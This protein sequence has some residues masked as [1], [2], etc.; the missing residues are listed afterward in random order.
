MN[1]NQVMKIIL[2]TV[3]LSSCRWWLKP[4]ALSSSPYAVASASGHGV[5]PRRK[6]CSAVACSDHGDIC[7]RRFLE[8]SKWPFSQSTHSNG[9]KLFQIS[10]IHLFELLFFFIFSGNSEFS[11]GETFTN[12]S[13]RY[14]QVYMYCLNNILGRSIWENILETEAIRQRS[15]IVQWTIC[16]LYQSQVLKKRFLNKAS[17]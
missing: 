8:Y 11:N 4:T 5:W 17:G 13:Q 12:L 7:G 14:S 10:Y 6:P 9:M 1:C 15:L 3:F 2:L 16:T